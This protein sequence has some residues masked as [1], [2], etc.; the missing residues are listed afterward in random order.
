M[1][2]QEEVGGEQTWTRAREHQVLVKGVVTVQP[3]CSESLAI[4][5]VIEHT[6]AVHSPLA[7]V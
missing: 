6:T 2:L 4:L 7:E 3:F 5:S 1:Q